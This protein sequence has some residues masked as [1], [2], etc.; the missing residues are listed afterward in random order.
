M[1]LRALGA[2]TEKE[3]CDPVKGDKSV[4]VFGA[5]TESCILLSEL[6][7]GLQQLIGER[8]VHIIGAGQIICVSLWMRVEHIEG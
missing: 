8:T 3:N 6:L 5:I 2:E 7:V 4:A 1:A